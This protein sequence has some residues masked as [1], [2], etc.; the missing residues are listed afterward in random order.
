MSVF[1]VSA[2]RHD[3]FHAGGSLR[4]ADCPKTKKIVKSDCDD[5][6]NEYI[7]GLKPENNHYNK[8]I[9]DA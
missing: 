7:C 9:Q 8:T 1:I 2:L 4:P 3:W 6:N 5:Q